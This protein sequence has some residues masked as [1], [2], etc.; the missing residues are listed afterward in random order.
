MWK[1]EYFVSQVHLAQ[2]EI[3]AHEWRP[4]SDLASL[5]STSQ[6][7]LK[8]SSHQSSRSAVWDFSYSIKPAF[9]HN[10]QDYHHLCSHPLIHWWAKPVF[11]PLPNGT[12]WQRDNWGIFVSLFESGLQRLR[13]CI[14]SPC[15]TG[16]RAH[17]RETSVTCC[18]YTTMEP[19]LRE[20]R[21]ARTRWELH[22]HKC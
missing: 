4:M 13:A 7:L 8:Q 12:L 21:T 16:P 19:K 18:R 2:D 11:C 20:N 6:P 15:I 5:S 17:M 9:R 22:G 1:K 14:R 10:Y 3:Y